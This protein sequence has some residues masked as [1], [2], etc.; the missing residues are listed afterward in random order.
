MEI[1]YTLK[2]FDTNPIGE[3][4]NLTDLTALR[5]DDI[6]FEQ[7]V[8]DEMWLE[9]GEIT[10]QTY[11][12]I[13]ASDWI[14]LYINDILAEVFDFRQVKYDEKRGKYTYN[15][16]PI[17]RTFMDDLAAKLIDYSADTEDWAYNLPDAEVELLSFT[18][19]DG[20]G[21]DQTGTDVSGYQPLRMVLAMVGTSHRI[22]YYVNAA[23]YDGATITTAA[24]DKGTLVRG[25][26]IS[27]AET[28]QNKINGTFSTNG[29]EDFDVNWFQIFR[30][31]SLS[32]NA[33]IK[34]T[35]IIVSGTPD[36]L[37]I[38]IDIM[39]RVNVSAGT[40]V[41]VASFVERV[42][43]NSKY[44]IHGVLITGLNFEYRL[45]NWQSPNAYQ[46]DIDVYDYTV[47]EADY[48]IA[49]YYRGYTG[50]NAPYFNGGGG[51]DSYYSGLVSSGHGYDGKC[52]INYN[53]GAEKI[54]KVLDQVSF[55]ST[56]IMLTRLRLGLSSLADYEG[57]IIS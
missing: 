8:G 6:Q 45:S 10:I 39:P 11:T 55:D 21:N 48:A 30:I 35:P 4:S 7:S 22:G 51:V 9:S 52:N 34:I 24:N 44:R 19:K 47:N 12:Q 23:N 15:L 54:L 16:Y 26:G 13:T 27:T 3:I 25:T 17:Q 31:I 43:V 40:P 28:D 46:R 5:I 49:L 38:I 53:D 37:G 57:I 2:S 1:T 33:Y 36:R 42:K 41:S 14:A 56:T 18:V 29:T 32:Y 20:D 50:G